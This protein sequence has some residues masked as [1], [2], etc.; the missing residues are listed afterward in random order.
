MATTIDSAPKTIDFCFNK[1]AFKVTSTH[2]DTVKIKIRIF[3]EDV[4]GSGDYE[5]LPY[6]Y[7]DVDAN[8]SV[9]L[10]VGEILKNYFDTIK[11]DI[12]GLAGAVQDTSILKRYG[13]E[14]WGIDNNNDGITDE[15]I[16]SD[17]LYMLYGRLSYQEWPDHDFVGDLATNLNFL[18]NIGENIRTWKSAKHYL[19]F[20]NHV[21]GT[22]NINIKVT[23]YFTDKT[24]ESFLL[25]LYAYAN[26]EQYD[27]LIIAAGYDQLNI[28]GLDPAKT[29]YKYEITLQLDDNTLI[30]R[31][32]TFHLIEK[33]WWGKQFVFRNNFGALETI[34]A[35]GKE[36][37]EVTAEIETSKKRTQYDYASRDFEYVQRIKSRK[38]EFKCSLG[39]FTQTEA[40]HLEEMLN[41]K[42]FK[43]GDTDFIPCIILNKS[44][45]PYS[46]NED[47]Q[48]IELHYQYAF[49][50]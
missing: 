28:G 26:A 43:I 1:P 7:L 22:N 48:V 17:T 41:D 29:V 4:Y 34:I 32:I 13:V 12:F 36:E 21:S 27:V 8:G 30:S 33:P 24:S 47:L 37:S 42:L 20:M 23:A 5:G 25:T 35:E 9:I 44:I 11:T 6:M 19:Y 16:T 50:I 38:K 49:D 39:P 15:H 31:T 14:F 18:N 46:E 2:V 40:E 10:H 45:K 3:V